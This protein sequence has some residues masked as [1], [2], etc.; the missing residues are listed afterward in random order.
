MKNINQLDNEYL[1]IREQ[2]ERS[3][4][5]M[6]HKDDFLEIDETIDKKHFNIK[7]RLLTALS[8]EYS[9][10]GRF[11]EA[12]DLFKI[13]VELYEHEYGENVREIPFYES[14]LWNY[15]RSLYEQK[16]Y[17]KAEAEFKKLFLLDPRNERNKDWYFG[18]IKTHTWK[19]A[20]YFL[21]FLFF[22]MIMSGMLTHS[23][24]RE[25]WIVINALGLL[26]FIIGMSL[27]IVGGV[28]KWKAK[29]KA[30]IG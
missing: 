21:Y 3:L 9:S 1:A 18:T 12:S 8:F 17:G 2:K 5:L 15:A 6:D 20:R 7:S 27:E 13:V 10:M 23:I 11:S 16:K 26:S 25:L 4:F 22:S 29:Q 19:Q 28:K 14:L 30:K 24:N